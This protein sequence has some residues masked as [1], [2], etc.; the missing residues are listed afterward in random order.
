M[1]QL[2]GALQ[3]ANRRSVGTSNIQNEELE[4]PDCSRVSLP[5]SGIFLVEQPHITM[6]LDEDAVV[7]Q[8]PARYF[9]D[10][11]ATML[12]KHGHVA[13]CPTCAAQKVC[14][15]C[16]ETCSSDVVPATLAANEQ[17]GAI[18]IGVCRVCQ[19]VAFVSCHMAF[20]RA[21]S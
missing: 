11:I 1:K 17:Q 18:F 16:P 5:S 14:H 6:Q 12:S 4:R 3:V 8:I 9:A 20:C 2:L 15:V 13:R 7:N 10:G 19:I 21:K